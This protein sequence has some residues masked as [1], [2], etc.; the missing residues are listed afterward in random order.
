MNIVFIQCDS[1]DGRAMGNMNHP[2]VADATPN[3]DM[4]AKKGVTFTNT[5]CNNPICCPSRASMWSGR[6]THH[7]E[8]WNNYKGLEVNTPTFETRLK[9]NGYITQ[10][11]GKTDYLSGYHTIRA[12]VTAWTSSAGIRRPTFNME[13]P[14]IIDSMQKRVQAGDWETVDNGCDWLRENGK[15]D[16]PFMLYLG[17]NAPH[18]PFVTSKYYYNLINEENVDI[19]PED[20]EVHPVMEYQRIQKNWSYGFSEEM[21]R[22]TRH[23]YFAMIAEVDA[24]LGVVL[25]QLEALNLMDSTYVIFASDHGEMAMEHKQFYKMNLYEPSVRVPLLISGPGI[26]EGKS[27]DSLTSLID[28]YPTIMDMT[29]TK[30]PSDLDGHSL[31]R[32]LK[33]KKGERPDWV[34]TEFHGTTSNTGCF[35][36]RNKKWKYNVYVGYEP[37]LFDLEQDPYEINNLAKK[38]PD[39]VNDI[40]KKLRRI[41]DYESV[42]AKVK[43]YDKKS[44]AKWRAEHK[45]EGTYEENMAAIH[46]GWDYITKDNTKAWS[47]EN[48]R[49]IIDWLE[50]N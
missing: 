41:V 45:D 46:S 39:I 38:R 8:G 21:V 44:F 3:M 48:E 11:F 25:S 13:E 17:L 29:Q 22:K 20:K 42:D 36:L 26:G 50:G 1:M 35:M 4:L 47:E 19:P 31:M 28:I 27:I 24:M 6:F 18:P 33:G 37:Q 2:A 49:Q 16:R 5:Y 12:R 30:K 9:K 14:E 10:T 34:L 40:D 15:P 43:A 32:E 23:I 7:C